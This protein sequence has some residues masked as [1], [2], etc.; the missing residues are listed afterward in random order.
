MTR[1]EPYDESVD[2]PFCLPLQR[3]GRHDLE[4]AGGKGANLGELIAAGFD[5]PEGFVVT[6]AAYYSAVGP[7]PHSLAAVGRLAVP[8]ALAQAIADG[9]ASLGAGPVAV[10]SSATAEDLPGAAFAGQQETYLNVQG[11]A[12]VITAVRDC[13][14]SLWGERAI[15]Y[16]ARLGLDEST[17]A[18][19]VVVQRMVDADLAGVMF[20]ADP[21]TGRR[22]HVVIDASPGLGEA[23]VSGLVTPDHAVLDADNRVISQRAGGR[24]LTIRA[25]CGGGTV[26]DENAGGAGGAPSD[27]QLA[28]LADLGR[29]IATHFGGPQDVEW[30]IEGERIAIVQARPMTALPPAPV[31]LNAVQRFVGPVILEL[32]PRRPHPLELSAWSRSIGRHVE[33]LVDGLVGGHVDF[34]DV[35][36]T[37]D[38]VMVSYVPP[39]PHP[40]ARTPLRLLRTLWRTRRD[41]RAWRDDPAYRRFDADAGT[42]AA[43]DVAGAEWAELLAVPA[44][45]SALVDLMTELRVGYLPGAVGAML[46]LRLLLA[47]LRRSELFGALILELPTMTDRANGTLA[48][49]ADQLRGLP[50]LAERL[51]G[52]SPAAALEAIRR[53]PDAVDVRER[54]EAFLRRYGHRET[55][56]VLLLRDPSW[57]DEPTTVMALIQLL[58]ASPD[59]TGTPPFAPALARLLHDPVL[60]ATRSADWVGRL[61]TRA[62]A[63]VQVRED[64]H[65]EVTRAMPPVRHACVEAGRRLAAAGAIDQVDDVWFLTLE[66]LRSVPDPDRAGGAR[67]REAIGRRRALWQEL[68]G[69]PLI[70][71]ATLY[72]ARDDSDA[73]VTGVAGGGGVAEGPVRVIH[74]PAGF[75]ALRPGEVLVCPATN[76]SW[77]PLFSRAGAVVV[78]HGGIASHAA[79]VA[80][81]YGIPAVMG[82]GIGTGV[83]RD[84][85][86]VRVDGDRGRVTPA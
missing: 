69:A 17:V 78:D 60:T 54:L 71:T 5:V 44:R 21:V 36:V 15:A 57:A 40:T 26:T 23:V 38:E 6:T 4:L 31:P 53:D 61:V 41:P 75:G 24:E 10:R 51:A 33:G 62:S 80:R 73:L 32:L 20:T 8:G 67:L 1:T 65:F 68:A 64:T 55:G 50:D 66:E 76:P 72:P 49:I 7:G 47:V 79:I 12:A 30:A 22:D 18:I 48:L 70:A 2:A 27:G 34:N 29:R 56:S 77:T 19:A 82:T 63:G 11:E 52:L 3:L 43:L 13:W 45:A 46:R 84:G 14:A 86:R 25:A 74:S 9:Y 81:E 83:L 59:K 39:D 85:V 16:R 35:A 42:L 28:R 37:T 58:L